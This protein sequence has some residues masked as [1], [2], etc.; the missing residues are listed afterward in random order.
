MNKESLA[1]MV[2]NRP[3][4]LG[5]LWLGGTPGRLAGP[6]RSGRKRKKF[7][8][9]SEKASFGRALM[10]TLSTG[11]ARKSKSLRVRVCYVCVGVPSVECV[12][13]QKKKC[14]L[15]VFGCSFVM[16]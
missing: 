5:G 2:R 15:L 12:L 3:A 11:K 13:S 4:K 7:K 14:H 9:K 16:Y 8:A 10:S 6:G 1:K